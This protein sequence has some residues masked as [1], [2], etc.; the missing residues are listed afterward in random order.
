MVEAAEQVKIVKYASLCNAASITFEP[1]GLST[2]CGY[3]PRGA[4]LINRITL[5]SDSQ[6]EAAVVKRSAIM[7]KLAFAVMQQVAQQLLVLSPGFVPEP[8]PV[9]GL[10][11]ADPPRRCA[12]PRCFCRQ[13]EQSE[14]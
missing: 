12:R 5:C 2:W 1:L 6:G 10:G 8:R 3:G 14:P 11:P 4:A 9:C 7:Q 13:S